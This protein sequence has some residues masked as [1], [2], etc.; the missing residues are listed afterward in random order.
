MKKIVFLLYNQIDN[1]SE[2]YQK[3]IRNITLFAFNLLVTFNTDSENHKHELIIEGNNIDTMFKSINENVDYAYLVSYGYRSIDH[4]LVQSLIKY[5]ESN[6]YSVLGHI[7][8]DNPDNDE[9]GFYS[10]HHQCFLLNVKHWIESGKPNFGSISNMDTIL[11][12]V[13]RSE[14]N[15]HDNYTPYWIKSKGT[16][17]NYSG[18]V[19]EGWDLINSMLKKG[20]SIGNIP[21]ELRNLKQHIYPDV[22]NELEKL[23][24]N[25]ETV[26][27]TEPNQKYYIKMTD[28][29]SFQNSVYVFNT[30]S[31]NPPEKSIE[32]LDTIYCVAAGFKPIQLLNSYVWNEKTRMV[33]FDYSKSALNF[34]IWLVENWNGEDY[35]SI[36]EYYKE[37]IDNDFQPIKMPN[38][39]YISDWEKTIE[40]FGGRNN[41]INLWRSYQSI[42]HRFLYCNLFNDYQELIDDMS[43]QK[44]HKLIW[45]SNSFYT[46]ASL[47]NYK[48]DFLEK[49]YQKFIDDLKSNNLKLEVI[50]C[51]HAGGNGW[52]KWTN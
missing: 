29:S 26:E 49:T 3:H 33:Y 6:N 24:N 42:E 10:L 13:D 20:Y 45:F 52:M 43:Q 31:M 48:P 12:I 30:D 8:Q 46:E 23:L 9:K 47:R 36:I 37:N 2:E 51:N 18:T 38:Q 22:G 16:Q 11:E 27:I 35:P 21:I 5:A 17:R 41:W 25:E 44:G 7:L 40:I 1:R 14:E 50:G 28:F 34:K 19:R 15:F 39:D 32:T 4:C